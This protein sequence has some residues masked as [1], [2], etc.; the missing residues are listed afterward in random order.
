MEEHHSTCHNSKTTACN[1]I[2]SQQNCGVQF[3]AALNKTINLQ[4]HLPQHH[5]LQGEFITCTN[6]TA[7]RIIIELIAFT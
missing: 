2:Y 5:H 7:D 4:T 1:V 3:A 6:Y